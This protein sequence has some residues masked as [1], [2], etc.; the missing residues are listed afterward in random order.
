[1]T[2]GNDLEWLLYAWL[3]E[4]DQ[5]RA[6]GRFNDY[7]RVAFPD[8]CRYLRSLRADAASAEDIAQQTLIKFLTHL[9]TG[10][11][12]AAER[13]LDA[14]SEPTPSSLGRLHV[15]LA[16]EWRQHVQAFWDAA[17]GFRVVSNRQD[18]PVS[19]KERRAEINGRIESLTRQGRHMIEQIR[20]QC[21]EGPHDPQ[22]DAV[23]RAAQ[24]FLRCTEGICT[25]LPALAIPSN[26]LLYT[27]AKRR[28]IDSTRRSRLHPVDSAHI[29]GMG[30]GSVLEEIDLPSDDATLPHSPTAHE[31]VAVAGSEARGL[32]LEQ[33][34]VAFLE[35]LRTPLTRAE[36]AVAEAESRG[37]ATAECARAQSLRAKY[38]R[39]MAVLIALREHPQPT[40]QE[41]AGRLGLTRNQVKY[42]IE[43]IRSEFN[44]FFPDLARDAQGRRKKESTS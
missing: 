15:Q 19:W 38:D 21:T 28:F 39:L 7:F 12:V 16:Q 6:E 11:K 40:E 29:T 5:R 4:Q 10:R 24:P 3:A 25:N 17:I 33:R 42:A 23:A 8:L 35:F 14:L 36:A 37:K 30:G 2:S 18:G 13:I 22:G 44:Y 27:I 34:Y 31:P 32:A 26:G 43:R 9:G 1:M 20:R 41:I